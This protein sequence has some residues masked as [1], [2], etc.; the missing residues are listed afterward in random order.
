MKKWGATLP[1]TVHAL[2]R[3]GCPHDRILSACPR[4]VRSWRS[5]T[6]RQL[7]RLALVQRIHVNAC[8]EEERVRLS[9]TKQRNKPTGSE[10]GVP[11]TAEVRGQARQLALI[12]VKPLGPPPKRVVG[13]GSNKPRTNSRASS[14]KSAG[15]L[16][17]QLNDTIWWSIW[18][19]ARQCVRARHRT[20]RRYTK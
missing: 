3:H 11:D 12:A 18:A 9:G 19:H 1:P 16:R 7:W 8:I 10:I 4:S 15:K 14:G 20:G 13:F 2:G 6:N 5:H 17:S